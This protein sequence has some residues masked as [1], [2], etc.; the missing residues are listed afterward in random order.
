MNRYLKLSI[1]VALMVG[2]AAALGY[3]GLKAL[4][5]LRPKDEEGFFNWD[6]PGEMYVDVGSATI[7]V[8]ASHQGRD[9]PL[10]KKSTSPP[11]ARRASQTP[12]A[13]VPAMYSPTIHQ[14]SAIT[15]ARRPVGRLQP[16]ETRH[17]AGQRR[18]APS[19]P[20][21]PRRSSRVP[22]SRALRA[23][24]GVRTRSARHSGG[25]RAPPRRRDARRQ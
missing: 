2:V 11:L 3:A 8:P 16:R 23:G 12:S 20:R 6:G 19:L 14:S 4:L 15:R 24:G 5:G 25:D 1:P 21:W 18:P 9:R 22:P 7:E 10:T 13:S 17:R